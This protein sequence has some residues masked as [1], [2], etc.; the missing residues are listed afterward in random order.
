MKRNLI[1]SVVIFG[2][3]AVLRA[4]R[5]DEKP[6][7]SPPESKAAKKD[8]G[9]KKEK[10]N[11]PKWIDLFD[12]KTLKDWKIPNFG[13]Q[14][15]VEAKDGQISL[16]FGD[17]CT[18][19]TYTK[20]FPTE[21]FEIELEAMRV[22]GH[23][24]FCGLTFPVGKSPCTL[25][26]GG[27]GGALVGLSSIDDDDAANNDTTKFL[28]FKAKQWYKIRLRVTTE[29]IAA[30]IDDKPVV[31][32]DVRG[33]ELSIRSEVDL[34][35]PLGITSYKTEA[36]LK[37]IRYRKLTEKESAEFKPKGERKKKIEE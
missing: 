13:T 16:G 29:R 28:Q 21:D 20:D 7:A 3:L 22:D 1:L 5:A 2:M 26:V 12:G 19:V 25:I 14:G 31:D 36:A 15:D 27:W 33:N 9:D 37:N 6:K 30:W 32:R 18:G 23:D 35:K 11:E 8:A 34:S 10:S 17:G 24:F 4:G